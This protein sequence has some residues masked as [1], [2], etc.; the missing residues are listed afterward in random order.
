MNLHPSVLPAFK[1]QDGFGD[2][3]DYGAKYTGSTIHFIDEK[4]DEGKIIIQTVCPVDP[5]ADVTVTRHR[6]FQQQCKS[7]LQVIKWIEEKRI[8]ISGQHVFVRNASYLDFE[9]SPSLDYDVA[10]QLQIPF[11]KT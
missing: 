10:R 1:G 8:S 2:A 11:P 6:I 5:N 9:F 7:L 4:M 3:L